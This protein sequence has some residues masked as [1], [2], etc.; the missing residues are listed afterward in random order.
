[1]EALE[2]ATRQ[3]L[4][5][6]CSVFQLLQV[7]AS[8][9]EHVQWLLDALDPEDGAEIL[10]VGCG[11]GTVA[12]MMSEMQSSLRFT[13]V[14]NY[15]F[16]LERC[17]V[18][19]RL[20]ADMACMRGVGDGTFDHAMCLY[21]I[22][23]ARDLEAAAYEIRRVLRPGGTLFVYDFTGPADRVQE[24]LHYQVWTASE[25]RDRVEACGFECAWHSIQPAHRDRLAPV[26]NLESPE[27]AETLSSL[28]DAC[29]AHAWSFR[30]R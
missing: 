26:L 3:A 15:A 30:A 29:S 9:R 5:S 7:G 22:G 27:V 12:E 2:H 20:L 4:S 11:V 10:D 21:S 6:G 13:Q 1:M 19:R 18:G 25:F 28:V 8:E 14:N 23:Y 17:R 16:Q 24:I